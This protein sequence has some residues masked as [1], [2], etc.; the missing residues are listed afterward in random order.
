[1]DALNRE[2]LERDIKK[3]KEII[4]IEKG[5]IA[6][7][8]EGLALSKD[9]FCA[10]L[11]EW[12]AQWVNEGSL[13]N[14]NWEYL[15][16]PAHQVEGHSDRSNFSLFRNALKHKKATLEKQLFARECVLKRREIVKKHNGVLDQLQSAPES[17]AKELNRRLERFQDAMKNLDGY[18]A[19]DLEIA[20]RLAGVTARI[21]YVKQGRAPVG[22]MPTTNLI[23]PI[24]LGLK[25]AMKER[26]EMLPKVYRERTYKRAQVAYQKY[27]EWLIARYNGRVNTLAFGVRRPM[28]ERPTPKAPVRAAVPKT[29]V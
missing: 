5:Q 29:P 17:F 10:K 16:I 15:H 23:R 12:K 20:W 27:G 1:M 21:V 11:Q 18:K 7:C 24:K 22:E 26:S 19:K 2:F 28:N 14:M 9:E 13:A 3:D 4:E 8:A 6:K 25:A